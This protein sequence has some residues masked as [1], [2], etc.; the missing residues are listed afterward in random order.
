MSW[1]CR[2]PECMLESGKL[3]ER[4]HLYTRMVAEVA[5]HPG[6]HC[7]S[8]DYFVDTPYKNQRF[9]QA[10]GARLRLSGAH[11]FGGSGSSRSGGGWQK[12]VSRMSDE[13]LRRVCTLCYAIVLPARKSDLRAGFR[14][15]SNRGKLTI[16]P[17]AGRRPARG[18]IFRLSRLESSRNPARKLDVRPGS[19]IAQ[20]RVCRVHMQPRHKGQNGGQNHSRAIKPLMHQRMSTNGPGRGYRYHRPARTNG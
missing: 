18:P 7:L 16:G 17:P 12:L 9:P 19:T 6:L 4:F 3:W 2:T 10:L 1:H 11:F 15:D 5:P 20:H 14:P 13:P 8:G